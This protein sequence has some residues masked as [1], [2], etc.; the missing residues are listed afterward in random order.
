MEFALLLLQQQPAE[1][2]TGGSGS[3]GDGSGG[4]DRQ[5][6]RQADRLAGG[7]AGTTWAEWR[8]LAAL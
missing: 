4:S 7:L 6:D 1:T 8:A 5:T 3:G 2:R